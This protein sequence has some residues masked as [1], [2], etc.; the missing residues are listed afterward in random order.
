MIFDA[1]RWT[2]GEAR[3]WLRRH[4]Y[5][6]LD[7]DRTANTLRFRQRDPGSFRRDTF[8]TISM[9]ADTGIQAVVAVPR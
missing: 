3:A 1:G 6:G 4:A 5:D 7:P 8:R 9:G 2:L